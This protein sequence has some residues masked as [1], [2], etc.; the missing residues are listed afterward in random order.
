MELSLFWIS[1]VEVFAPE[2]QVALRLCETSISGSQST[3]ELVD[4]V[5]TTIFVQSALVNESVTLQVI[6]DPCGT[7]WVAAELLV[8]L[9]EIEKFEF[10]V[11]H[12]SLSI[13]YSIFT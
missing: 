7:D 10:F 11:C 12:P 1:R 2:A 6:A 8:E 13:W 9:P 4:S 3:V 5:S